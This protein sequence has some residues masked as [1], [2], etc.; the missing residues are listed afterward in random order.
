MAGA[1]APCA[2]C[3][4]EQ[5]FCW[6]EW[7][8]PRCLSTWC[9]QMKTCGPGEEAARQILS[10]QPSSLFQEVTHP[11]PALLRPPCIHA[12]R[13]L[14]HWD[15]CRHSQRITLSHG[16]WGDSQPRE[17]AWRRTW[18]LLHPPAGLWSCQEMLPGGPR[19]LSCPKL[20]TTSWQICSRRGRLRTSENHEPQIPSA[21]PFQPPKTA[22]AQGG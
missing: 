15:D 7:Q 9:A 18:C 11:D 14:G 5:S 10:R 1:A 22:L 17:G 19:W 8:S 21:A 13:H 12:G 20:I 2:G 3:I 6:W 4:S 16:V